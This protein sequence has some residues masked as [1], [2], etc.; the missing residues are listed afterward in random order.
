MGFFG[1]LYDN[2][3]TGLGCVAADLSYESAKAKA[4]KHG[5]DVDAEERRMYGAMAQCVPD[6]DQFN[7]SEVCEEDINTM[8]ELYRQV[9]KNGKKTDAETVAN[10]QRTIQRIQGGM[11]KALGADDEDVEDGDEE[12]L[13][14]TEP[15][16]YAEDSDVAQT[17]SGGNI[18]PSA[19]A[20]DI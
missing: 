1:S 6:K 12:E 19:M 17:V 5:I 15:V 7:L 4:K 14:Q 10:L 16:E 8:N 11:L 20:F 2:I 13:E 9:A 3:S 18:M